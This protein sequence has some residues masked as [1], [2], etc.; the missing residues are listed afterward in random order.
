MPRH[1]R[2]PRGLQQRDGAKAKMKEDNKTQY[3]RKL[4]GTIV[5]GERLFGRLTA[6]APSAPGVMGVLDFSNTPSSIAAKHGQTS[7]NAS[8][9]HAGHE[10][11]VSRTEASNHQASRSNPSMD[12]SNPRQSLSTVRRPT[13]Q[14]GSLAA[15][16]YQ[17]EMQMMMQ[18]SALDHQ[19]P[20]QTPHMLLSTREDH[21]EVLT[22]DPFYG[23]HPIPLPA[24]EQRLPNIVI[25]NTSF[26]QQPF[27]GLALGLPGGTDLHS[28]ANDPPSDGCDH[29]TTSTEPPQQRSAASNNFVSMS[30]PFVTE[31]PVPTVPHAPSYHTI[32]PTCAPIHSA[33]S[34]AP[35]SPASHFSMDHE[36]QYGAS[37]APP[38]QAV[39][40]LAPPLSCDLISRPSNPLVKQLHPTWSP[41]AAVARDYSEMHVNDPLY[42]S[43]P[44][45]LPETASIINDFFILTKDLQLVDDIKSCG[46]SGIKYCELAL[47][48]YTESGEEQFVIGL[49]SAQLRYIL[50]II[51]SAMG[52]Q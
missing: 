7:S 51:V 18:S 3:V 23:A 40:N 37:P 6:E 46:A 30:Q 52:M 5:H 48:F 38:A 26:T 42:G 28:A 11:V 45:P 17:S 2:P 19:L 1:Q 8:R 44:I 27:P 32:M 21:R 13:V 39:W 49:S 14:H 10:P 25:D 4:P 36:S 47:G 33:S 24:A 12:T 50:E 16:H 20:Q 9:L 22:Y 15:A 35:L 34:Q 41:R 43:H 29:V 31:L